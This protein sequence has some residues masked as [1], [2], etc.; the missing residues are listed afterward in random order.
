MRFA[1]FYPAILW[2]GQVGPHYYMSCPYMAASYNLRR[3]VLIWTHYRISNPILSRTL[4]DKNPKYMFAFTRIFAQEL[5]RII[6]L[7]GSF[8][9]LISGFINTRS[10]YICIISNWF[11][12]PGW[13]TKS[14]FGLPRSPSMLLT[15]NIK[16]H[17]MFAPPT[18][19]P[20]GHIMST[21]FVTPKCIHRNTFI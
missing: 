8:K 13:C 7:P 12:S 18:P 2:A 16:C 11:I 10:A 14:I 5:V 17:C 6:F 4:F 1:W 19:T 3:N 21:S 9:E 15:I 20:R